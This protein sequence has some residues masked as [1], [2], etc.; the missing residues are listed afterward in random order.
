MIT[1]LPIDSSVFPSHT[2]VSVATGDDDRH[3]V[4]AFVGQIYRLRY[5][6]RLDHFLPH[7]IAYRDKSNGLQAAVGVRDASD[8]PLFAEHYLD[9]PAEQ[10][11]SAY[12]G[13]QVGRSEL[14][15]VGNFAATSAGQARNVIVDLTFRLHRRGVRWVVFVATRQLRNAF[16]RLHLA[17]VEIADARP[18][19]VPGGPGEWG[20]YYDTQPK[21]MFG[22]IAAG[23]AYLTRASAPAT[24]ATGYPDSAIAG[25]CL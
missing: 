21:V 14:V 11:V 19:R 4:E 10:V 9:V 12:V 13:R 3:T 24:D 1:R 17:T 25:A 22:D 15:E 6:A 5:G 18:E 8:G 2:S 16:D 20:S 7:L 23:H